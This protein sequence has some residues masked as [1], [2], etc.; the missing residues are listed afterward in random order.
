MI[1]PCEPQLP[2]VVINSHQRGQA[3]RSAPSPARRFGMAIQQTTGKHRVFGRVELPNVEVLFFSVPFEQN[4]TI[5]RLQ[6]AGVA[7][8]K[9]GQERVNF[10]WKGTR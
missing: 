4:P 6:A 7:R 1:V 2:P 9:A 5:D 3:D 8:M 10:V